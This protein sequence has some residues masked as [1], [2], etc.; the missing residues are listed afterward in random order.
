MT[1]P[2][3][4]HTELE[5]ARREA[6]PAI[7]Y[8]NAARRAQH[9]TLEREPSLKTPIIAGVV[10][11]V[12]G[13][14]GFMGWAYSSNLD[15]ASVASGMVIADTK[16]K[17]VSHYEGGI[18]KRL[19]VKEGELVTAGQPLI[20]LDDTRARSELQQLT[21]RRFALTAKLARLR[22][23]QSDAASVEFPDD[24]LQSTEPAAQDAIAAEQRFFAT[25]VAAK[26]GRLDVQ[27]KSIEQHEAEAQAL[28]AQIDATIRQKELIQEQRDTI[29]QLVAKGYA[30]R[31]QLLELDSRASQLVGNGGEMAANKAK[32]ELAKAG[33]KLELLALTSDWLQQVAGD[34]AT[35]RGDLADVD[36]KIIASRDVLRRLEV[37]SP[38]AGVIVNSQIRT[39]GAAISAGAPLMDIV[40]ENEPLIIEARVAPTDIDTIRIGQPVRVR[41][42]AYNQRNHAPL[43]GRVIYVGADQEVDPHTNAAYFVTRSEVLP[44]SLASAAGVKLYPGM[45]ADVLIINKPRLAIDYLL[46]PITDSLNAAFHEE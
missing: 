33:A 34:I 30:K 46:S 40:P 43:D 8:A 35:T 9:E 2:K 17:T 19:L 11:V 10:A 28:T 29:A 6:V 25:R 18:L 23:E 3:Q 15:S 5:K 44:E 27:K 24:L 45:P 31:S 39:L 16:R 32:A 1:L 36:E 4:T 12:V 21:S 26:S 22:S 7:I 41:L 37:R 38:E 42:T 20:L 13:F 14:G